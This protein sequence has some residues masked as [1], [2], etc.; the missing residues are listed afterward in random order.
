MAS[1]GG[2]AGEGGEKSGMRWYRIAARD[3]PPQDVIPADES[4]EF[5]ANLRSGDERSKRGGEYYSESPVGE[6][7]VITSIPMSYFRESTINYMRE[8]TDPGRV[9][10]YEGQAIDTPIYVKVN[11]R[12]NL[13]ISDGG[14]RFMAAF[15]RGDEE[16][17]VVMSSEDLARIQEK[18]P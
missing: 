8:T 5:I 12:G 9:K 1:S 11:Q 13:T 10:R 17:R 6:E 3:M 14:H 16:V 4:T 2:A 7:L 18:S 15:N